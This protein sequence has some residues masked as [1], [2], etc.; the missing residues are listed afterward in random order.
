MN[1]H[2]FARPNGFIL[3]LCLTIGLAA[4]SDDGINPVTPNGKSAVTIMD[5]TKPFNLDPPP[6][7]WRHRTFWTRPAMKV[8][9]SE[10][11]GVKALRCETNGSG[12]IFGRYTDINLG[13][14]PTL[15]WQWFIEVPIKSTLDERTRE[16]DD[17]P[18]RLFIRFQDTDGGDH[19]TEIIWSNKLFAPGDYKYIGDFPHYVANGR[20]DNIGRWH[21]EK[22]NLL[23]IYRKA[24]KRKDAPNVKLIAIFCD[25]DDT[26]GRSVAYFADIQLHKA[27]QNEN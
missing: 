24:T 8:S 7:G 12:S 9:L 10:K 5:F 18:A 27:G 22:I 6:P 19:H 15:T 20:N 2:Y 26:G 4:C 25:S 17:H 23:A 1:T 3:I 21:S 11:A 14:Y 13:R 16:G